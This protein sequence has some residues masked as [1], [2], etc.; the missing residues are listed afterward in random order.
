MIRWVPVEVVDGSGDG[1]RH[2][3]SDHSKK[4]RRLQRART[5]RAE[6][7]PTVLRQI[8]AVDTVE[9]MADTRSIQLEQSEVLPVSQSI[10]GTVANHISSVSN[11]SPAAVWARLNASCER[12]RPW[13]PVPGIRRCPP[14]R[15]RHQPQD[16]RGSTDG[17]NHVAR[18]V[19]AFGRVKTAVL[20]E[21]AVPWES[22]GGEGWWIRVTVLVKPRA[23]AAATT[24]AI[25]FGGTRYAAS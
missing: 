7:L 16:I 8:L 19:F 17:D 23:A 11:R 24:S 22:S 14:A 15:V 13:S 5:R 1:T 10:A 12:A 9:M 4:L 18:D 2:F 20:L 3:D 21:D 6:T 25:E